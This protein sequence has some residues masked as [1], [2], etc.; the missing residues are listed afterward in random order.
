MK[1]QTFENYLREI[2]AE[3]YHGLDDDMPDDFERFITETDVSKIM[4]WA[5][6]WGKIQY[7]QG[8]IDAYNEVSSLA[9]DIN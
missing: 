8:Q 9:S 6:L 3:N 4:E 7:K 2:H 5:E 1:N